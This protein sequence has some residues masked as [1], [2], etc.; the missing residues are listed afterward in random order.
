MKRF[1]TVFAVSLG[2]AVFAAAAMV[3]RG[4]EREDEGEEEGEVHVKLSDCAKAVQATIRKAT[5]GGKVR[6]IEGETEKG[7]VAYEAEY[8]VKG[9]VYE[10]TVSE[11]G[12][13]LDKEREDAEDDDDDDDADEGED[14][15]DDDDAD[16]GETE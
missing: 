3:A 4:A 13:L 12:K 9:K 10:I 5:E 16:E 6:E 11:D 14:D 2:L 7:K 1:A 15:D 8:V